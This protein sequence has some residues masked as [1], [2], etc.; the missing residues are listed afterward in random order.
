M[1]LFQLDAQ[2][3]DGF[4]ALHAATDVGSTKTVEA[5]LEV[6]ARTDVTNTYRGTCLH[7]AARRNRAHIAETLLQNGCPVDR[8]NLAGQTE[9]TVALKLTCEVPT[10]QD[11]NQASRNLY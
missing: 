7:T 4:T 3:D 1:F 6:G 2:N 5:L 8:R 11:K 9:V 10:Q